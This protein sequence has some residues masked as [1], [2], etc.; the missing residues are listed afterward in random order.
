MH[1]TAW[2]FSLGWLRQCY[3][4][5]GCLPPF[6]ESGDVLDAR[7]NKL[8]MVYGVTGAVL[9]FVG[10]FSL[11]VLEEIAPLFAQ[12][13]GNTIAWLGIG[14]LVVGYSW[15]ASAKG[16]HWAWGFMG[17]LSF[18]GLIMLAVMP[19]QELRRAASEDMSLDV[20]KPV[21]H[22]GPVCHCIGC[23][24][25]LNGITSPACPECGRPFDANDP[26]SMR[27]TDD[28]GQ[29]WLYRETPLRTARCSLICG[30]L[31]FVFFLIP[32]LNLI[33]V[34]CGI[35]FGHV[36]RRIA[37]GNP[38]LSTSARVA[39]TGLVF[40]YNGLVLTLFVTVWMIMKLT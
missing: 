35:C 8:N 31:T 28:K 7:K 2:A 1:N 26:A 24:Y 21:E 9:L 20:S 25:I 30:L 29:D 23:D 34:I 22:G 11:R 19:D 36:A 33:L 18:I 14:L 5:I 16:L 37:R 27:V 39:L 3:E 6:Y 10:I 12:L 4:P 15:Y 13:I 32:P 40:S 17:P 38:N